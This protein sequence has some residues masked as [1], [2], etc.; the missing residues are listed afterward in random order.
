MR[1]ESAQRAAAGLTCID[2]YGGTRVS[3]QTW[4]WNGD[5]H[6]MTQYIIVD[7][8]TLWIGK[9]ACE[10]RAT[11]REELTDLLLSNGCSEVIRKFPDEAGFAK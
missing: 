7:D 1:L 4:V 9:F 5:N 3:F 6:Q 8:E 11:R 10:H 2:L